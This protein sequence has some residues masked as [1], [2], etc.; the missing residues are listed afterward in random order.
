MGCRI[1]DTLW[2]DE[3]GDVCNL[4]DYPYDLVVPM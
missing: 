2:L 4:T 3:H 1:E